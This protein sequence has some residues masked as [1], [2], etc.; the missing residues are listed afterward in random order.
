MSTETRLRAAVVAVVAVSIASCGRSLESAVPED[1]R[2]TASGDVRTDPPQEPAHVDFLPGEKPLVSRSGTG[3]ADVAPFRAADYRLLITC[4]GG[5]LVVEE[6]G[7]E[8]T[9]TTCDGVTL[10]AR[11]LAELGEKV[12]SISCDGETTWELR[13]ASVPTRR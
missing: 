2:T 6:A 8:V 5:P 10:D 4:H 7:R 9:R 3:P 12:L 11:V 1:A 13:A